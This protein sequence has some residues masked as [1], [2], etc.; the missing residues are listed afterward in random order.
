MQPF[1]EEPNR[2]EVMNERNVARQQQKP[3]L[4]N[5]LGRGLKIGMVN[6]EGEHLN[7]W[8]MHDHQ[9]IPIH[10]E[11]VSNSLQWNDLYPEWIDEEEE[12]ERPTCPQISMPKIESYGEMDVIVAKVACK[13]PEE[14][15]R[16]DVFRLQVQLIA[17]NLAV[18]KGKRKDRKGVRITNVVFWSK[19]RPMLELFRCDDLVMREGDWWWFMPEME[20]LEEKVA[21]PVGSCNLAWPLEGRGTRAV[22]LLGSTCVACVIHKK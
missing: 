17:A 1:L 9:I 18:K 20:R 11:R 3:S 6:M 7:E 19:C 10:F 22:F 12:R 8:E 5:K 2:V 16:R 14:G 13:W 15:W 4:L 21:L